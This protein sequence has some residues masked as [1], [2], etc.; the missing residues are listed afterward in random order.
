VADGGASAL[1]FKRLVSFIRELSTSAAHTH[2][3]QNLE[4]NGSK[5]I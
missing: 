3:L 5:L 4:M 2:H 1:E